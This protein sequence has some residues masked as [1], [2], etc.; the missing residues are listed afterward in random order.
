MSTT[1]ALRFC[2]G[3]FHATPWGRH[4]NEA[5]VE[6]PPSPWR[7]LRALVW[8]WKHKLPDLLT[9]TEAVELFSSL[10]GHAPAFYLPPATQAHTRH[11]MPWFKKGPYDKTLVFDAFVAVNRDDAVSISWP[12]DLPGPMRL[13]LE[14]LLQAL[15]HFGRAESWCDA[16]LVEGT[17]TTNCHPVEDQAQPSKNASEIVTVLCADASSA[18]SNEHIPKPKPAKGK[19]RNAP[20]VLPCDPPWHLCLD[21]AQLQKAGWSDPPGSKWVRYRRDSNAFLPKAAPRLARPEPTFHLARFLVDSVVRPLVTDTLAIADVTRRYLMGIH[22]RMEEQ[23]LGIE[24]GTS[25]PGQCTSTA[26]SGKAPDGSPLSGHQHAYFMPL[27]LD[28]D[29]RID[30]ILVVAHGG[31]SSAEVAAL[32]KLSTIPTGTDHP[33]RLALLGLDTN[34]I[35]QTGTHWVS[36]TPYLCTRFPKKRGTKRDPEAFFKPGGN[37]LLL[38]NDIERQIAFAGLPQPTQIVPCTD[39]HHVFRLQ[40]N[41][42]RAGPR[43]IDFMTKRLKERHGPERTAGF[44]TLV[45]PEPINGPIALGHNAHY[46]L[47]LFTAVPAR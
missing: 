34:I 6:W 17:P 9:T 14:T 32:R 31:F 44:F 29:G 45:F 35:A 37:I 25:A 43:T 8:V 38:Q 22:R 13:K 19:A 20:I 7:L 42:G 3:R 4:V 28:N 40:R 18:F 41:D 5:A 33:V 2:A 23:R 12:C 21:T 26:F 36:A 30:Q 1:I 27:D 46:G 24:S 47:G 11:Y 10:A 15:G 39:N 16:S